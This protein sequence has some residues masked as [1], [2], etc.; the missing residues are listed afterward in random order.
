MRKGMQ[1]NYP[2]VLDKNSYYAPIVIFTFDERESI[3]DFN[4]TAQVLLNA[5]FQLYRG[6]PAYELPLLC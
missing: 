2:C 3:V 4:I 5:D 6:Q 1:G